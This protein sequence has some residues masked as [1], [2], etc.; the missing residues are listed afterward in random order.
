M[1][2]AL[3]FPAVP[4]HDYR[5]S[6]RGFH[7]AGAI[8]RVRVFEPPG[9]APVIMVTELPENR[10]T[11]V[12]NLAEY[13]AAELLERHFPERVGLPEPVVWIEHYPPRGKDGDDFDRV[14]FADWR[15]RN[16]RFNNRWRRRVGEPEWRRLTPAQVSALIGGA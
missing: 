1:D 4:T 8:C 14:E 16:E 12:T 3:P 6:F 5:H 11:S 9:R 10:N 7:T 15:P 2:H 13:L